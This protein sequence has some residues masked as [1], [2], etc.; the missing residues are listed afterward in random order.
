MLLK[1]TKSIAARESRHNSEPRIGVCVVVQSMSSATA[2]LQLCRAARGESLANRSN[3][4]MMHDEIVT[5]SFQSLMKDERDNE[6]KVK[7]CVDFDHFR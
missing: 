6:L 7:S 2:A 5:T 4:M 3:V 1:K